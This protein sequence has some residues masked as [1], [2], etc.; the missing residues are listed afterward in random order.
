MYMIQYRVWK[1]LEVYQKGFCNVRGHFVYNIHGVDENNKKCM[2]N[3]AKDVW[4]RFDV[5]IIEFQVRKK[6]SRKKKEKILNREKRTWTRG[7]DKSY[8]KINNEEIEEWLAKHNGLD[9]SNLSE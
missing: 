3:V 4:D 8:R 1:E 7:I 6:E 2:N 9:L 5:P